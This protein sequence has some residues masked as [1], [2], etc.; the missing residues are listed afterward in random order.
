MSIRNSVIITGIGF[1]LPDKKGV[2]DKVDE[3]WNIV[4]NGKSNLSVTNLY[5]EF[6]VKVVG[7]IKNLDKASFNMPSKYEKKYSRAAFIASLAVRNA[8]KDAGLT[9]E[10]LSNDR[11]LLISSSSIYALEN[12]SKQYERYM[13]DGPKGVGFDYFLQGTP[14]SVPC[15][16]SKLL[17][18]DCP[19]MT[20][21]G[22]CVTGPHALQIA[23]EKLNIG[24]ID[25]AIIVGVEA[26]ITPLYLASVS[27]RM[28]NNQTI[29][30][31]SH[32]PESVKPHDK[33]LEGNACGEGGV[34]IILE[35]GDV[36]KKPAFNTSRFNMYYSNSRKNGVSLFDSGEP[37]NIA[38]TVKNALKEA[39]ICMDDV[40]FI[41]DF[42][43]GAGF[44]EDFFCEA[45]DDIRKELNYSN[46]ILL[47]NQEA[48]FGHIAGITG[49]VKCISNIMMMNEGIVTPVINCKEK[50][51]KLNANP[52]I[53]KYKKKKSKYSMFINV[54]AGGD[55]TVTLL[56]KV[57]DQ[58]YQ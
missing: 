51:D 5:P 57:L 9:S 3:F 6:N 48:A 45:I 36:E 24:I 44:I 41:N 17:N 22:S 2:C 46:E 37:S 49:L 32:D 54:G 19:M 50:Y 23:Y 11:T 13:K 25:R 8:M 18:L 14:P 58:H 20:L 34:A 26:N 35:K 1:E 4:K 40:G 12:V 16:V 38:R 29:N 52:V 10:E 56:E 43:E 30:T 28:K 39:N 7:E 31:M 33:N 55:C 21:G 53:G 42:T 47:T 15:A 27:Y